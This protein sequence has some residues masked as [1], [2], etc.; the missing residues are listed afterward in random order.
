MSP[1]PSAPLP[2]F[3]SLGIFAN[4]PPDQLQQ[5]LAIC[6]TLQL[7]PNEILLAP[8]QENENLYVLLTGRLRVHLDNA[9]SHHALLVEPGQFMGEMSIIE[10][11]RTSAYVV[12]DMPSQVLLIHE[13]LFW[14]AFIPLPHAVR[15]LLQGF[16][17][18]MRKHNE[19]MLQTLE[20][21]LRFEHLQKELDMAGNIQANIL[22]KRT[23]L[24]PNHPQVEAFGTVIPAKEVGGDFYDAFVVDHEHV[25]LVAGDVAGKGM[26]AALFMMR[27]ITLLRFSVTKRDD[28]EGL[29]PKI[30]LILCENNDDC[31]FVT[32]FVAVLNVQT[33]EFVYANGG[34][35][36][37]LLS[38]A[39]APFAPIDVP[40]TIV[41]GVMEMAE[42]ELRS[43]WLKPG[44]VLLLYTDGVT[45]AEGPNGTFYSL[46]RTEATL[47][48]LTTA[49]GEEIDTKTIVQELYSDVVQ[50][51]Q[52][53][54]QS[55]DITLLAVRYLGD[56]D[57]DGTD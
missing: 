54:P 51:A 41:V 38:R 25:C 4:I 17:R 43:L 27:V 16:S 33:G 9:D 57:V 30:N 37:P 1:P 6:P 11:A 18:R 10:N 23:P 15:N 24:F 49:V 55:D 21:R 50:F 22:P 7:A 20:E 40:R 42:Y 47:D 44:D 45:E 52:G 46:A 36:A 3:S 12:A 56:G 13:K 14:E 35:N 26:A 8:G 19:A 32:L 48:R 39:G 29:L 31:M 53:V 34:H 2:D 28:L 5:L